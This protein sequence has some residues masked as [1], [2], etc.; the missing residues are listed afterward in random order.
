MPV[1]EGTPL[2]AEA[3]GRLSLGGDDVTRFLRF[4]HI[5]SSAIREVL[6]TKLVQEVSPKRLTCSQF[7]MLRLIALDGDPQVGQVAHFLGISAAAACKNL[8]ALERLGLI[9]RSHSRL[10][11]RATLLSAS[12]KGRRVVR[13]YERLA[14]ERLAPVLGGLGSARVAE[15]CELL[16]RVSVDLLTREADPTGACLRC[17]SYYQVDCPVESIHN[18]CPVGQETRVVT[19]RERDE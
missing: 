17:S 14:E 15:L 12:S 13:D 3:G 10:D 2:T 11:R 9:R 5:F 18:G 16:E 1:K 7:R 4:S 19:A 8:D 6:D